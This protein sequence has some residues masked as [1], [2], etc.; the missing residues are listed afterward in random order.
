M[1]KCPNCG[2]K[3]SDIDVLCP[4]CG[5]FVE[6]VQ[7]GNGS[8]LSAG[9]DE[10]ANLNTASD[11]LQNKEPRPELVLYNEDMP[12]EID[13]AAD[14]E[15]KTPESHS[16]NTGD[17]PKEDAKNIVPLVVDKGNAIVAET[18]QDGLPPI[19]VEDISNFERQ[20]SAIPNDTDGPSLSPM[21][22]ESGDGSEYS[23]SYLDTIK[24][25]RLPEVEDLRNFDPEAFLS[26]YMQSK[27]KGEKLQDAPPAQDMQSLYPLDKEKRWL[28]LEE[29]D[30]L[31]DTPQET[32]QTPPAQEPTEQTSY[33]RQG[34]TLS[35][36]DY[37]SGR[38]TITSRK[39][40][41][42]LYR[43]LMALFWIV[44][45]AVVFF[46]FVI[47]DHFVIDTYGNY[48]HMIDTI[49]DGKIIIDTG[50]SF[51]DT[52]TVRVTE[53]QTKDGSSAHLFK[54]ETAA[55]ES[56]TVFPLGE[57]FELTDGDAA[58]IV[59]DVVL[60][61]AL[62]VVTFET[63]YV[64][65]AVSLE[66]V[67]NRASYNYPINTLTLSLETSAYVRSYPTQSFFSTVDD[68]VDVDI[69]VAPQTSISING[70]DY[71]KDIDAHGSLNVRLPLSLGINDFLIEALHPGKA[72]VK[73]TFSVTRQ[74]AQTTLSPATD[75]LRIY[76]DTFNCFGTT[77]ANASVTAIVD[78]GYAYAALVN[79]DG[80]YSLSCYVD[81]YGLHDVRLTA[82]S[83][84]RAESTAD[85]FVEY[86]PGIN[87]FMMDAQTLLLNDV[88]AHPD[89]LVRASGSVADISTIGRTQ[90]F[91]LARGKTDLL[92]HYYGTTLL[93]PGTEYTIF[94][95]FDTESASFYA[96]YIL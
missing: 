61:E 30:A 33:R 29:T 65:E 21:M 59:P 38:T 64:T 12:S 67:T 86:V 68:T 85:L 20:Q 53:T 94:G 63:Q 92:C 93:E 5:T 40:R 19:I 23:E 15:P 96:M 27:N 83:D 77:D 51:Q 69:T 76:S 57:S 71:T 24:N 32:E 73:D 50:T 31:A 9:K 74:T 37:L 54:I 56:V 58:I 66:V 6:V 26:E 60:L 88:P 90:S 36:N 46:G 11:I 4:K 10:S 62:N 47:L 17:A 1:N 18:P 70:T 22:P 44:L 39:P 81:E 82:T 91:T 48:N 45:T 25:M 49:T 8:I 42:V 78:A 79:A 95:M 72:A 43:V 7:V 84:V 16:D 2:N 3:L 87:T 52:T 14:A 13:I 35:E 34:N 80:A 89:T 28:E 75:Y 55:G 41:K